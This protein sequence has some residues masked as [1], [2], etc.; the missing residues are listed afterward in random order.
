MTGV[1]KTVDLS[2]GFGFIKSGGRELFFHRSACVDCDFNEFRAGHT[3]RFEE[4]YNERGPRAER[5]TIAPLYEL[6]PNDGD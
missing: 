1:V 6:L 5:V 4:V 3:V 2:R